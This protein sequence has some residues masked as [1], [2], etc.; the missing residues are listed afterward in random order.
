[1]PKTPTDCITRDISNV[2]TQTEDRPR[3]VTNM[4]REEYVTCCGMNPSS[5]SAGLVGLDDVNPTA[6][7]MAWEN[8]DNTTRTAASQDRLDRGTLAH[9]MV[10][11]PELLMDRVAIWQG[12]RR[13][14]NEWYQ[15]EDDN[16]GKLIV[17]STD[18]CQ[19]AKATNIMRSQ[20]PVASLLAASEYEVAMFATE[21]CNASPGYIAVKGQVDCVNRAGRVIV[22][23]KTTEAGIDTRSVQ[24]TIRTFHYREKMALYRRWIA[25]ESGTDPDAWKCYNVFMSL[26]QPYGVVIVKFSDFA[27]QWGESRM[28]IALEGVDQ[29]LASN[30]WPLY[31]REMFM[32][33]EQWEMNDD[34]GDIEYE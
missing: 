28:M 21:T 22:D 1:V 31:L 2:L 14:S 8:P 29:C 34:E 12:G 6:I 26:E 10:L 18:Y 20:A 9:L 27:L 23:L 32:N 19:V 24:R 17:K 7:K 16:K 33:V 25:R 5:L 4:T 15:F 3:V 11:Q 13:D 30:V